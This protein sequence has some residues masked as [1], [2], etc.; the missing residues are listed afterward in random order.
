MRHLFFSLM[1]LTALFLPF[2]NALGVTP[3]P[4]EIERGIERKSFEIGKHAESDTVCTIDIFRVSDM[5][6]SKSPKKESLTFVFDKSFGKRDVFGEILRLIEEDIKD[7]AITKV[8]ID[9]NFKK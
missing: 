9:C 2:N 7:E 4:T 8:S 6:N 1:I 5:P 3:M